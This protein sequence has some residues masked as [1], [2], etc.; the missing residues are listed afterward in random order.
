MRI[1]VCNAK[2]IFMKKRIIVAVVAAAVAAFLALP[3]GV[4]API[5]DAAYCLA[6]PAD[7]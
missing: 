5:V 2:G 1:I 7:C 4:V 6:L 3:S